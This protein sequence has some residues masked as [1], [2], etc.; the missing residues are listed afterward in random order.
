MVTQRRNYKLYKANLSSH[1]TQ[2]RID[3]LEAMGFTWTI[4]SKKF[5]NLDRTRHLSWHSR[6]EELCKFK[7]EHGIFPSPPTR[8]SCSPLQT[9]VVKQRRN[10]KRCKVNLSSPMT[11]ERIDALGLTGQRTKLVRI[12]KVQGIWFGIVISKSCVSS[13]K[14][15]ASFPH[16]L[17]TCVCWTGWLHSEE[18]TNST[19]PIYLRRWRKRGLMLWKQLGLP[20]Q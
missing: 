3:A 4:V 19:R 10:Y 1:T 7:E 18:I 20:G 15:M 11:Q 9:W 14:N 12:G 13:K 8:P 6:L 16:V 2:E 5:E 17:W